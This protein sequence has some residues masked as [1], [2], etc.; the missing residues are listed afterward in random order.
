M[1]MKTIKQGSTGDDVKILQELLCKWGLDI[2]VSL[3]FDTTTDEAVRQVQKTGHL[4]TDGIVG[5]RTWNL[6]QDS[7]ARRMWPLR[8]K[9]EDYDHAVEMLGVDTAAIKAVV[10]VETGN[11]GGFLAI[12]KPTILFEG[13]I[14]WQQ[15]EKIGMNPQNLQK[16]N[17]DIIYQH[18]TKSQ[19]KGGLKEYDR[20]EHARAINADAADASASW[21]L[22]QIMGFN[23]KVCGCRSVAEFVASMTENESRQLELFV[24]FI[25]GN[26]WVKYLSNLDW[27]G[28][29]YHYNGSGYAQNQ[30]DQ[31]LERAYKKYI[32]QT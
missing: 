5:E 32:A 4:D 9:E 14:F 15:L 20:L 18:W 22:P 26:N 11:K 30:Y 17:E 27:K 19:Y 25:S 1:N 21:G 16:G 13:H 12:G 6:L 24:R 10:E 23:Y 31:R 7:D 3:N 2:D 8:L 29:A 28:F